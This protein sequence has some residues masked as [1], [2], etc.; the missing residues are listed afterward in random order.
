MRSYFFVPANKFNNLPAIRDLGVDEIIIDFEDS[1]LTDQRQ[2]LLQDIST[3]SGLNE[4][5]YRIPLRNAFEDKLDFNY[6]DQFISLGIRKVLVPKLINLQ[7]AKALFEHLRDRDILLILLI[8]HPRLLSDL[9]EILLLNESF[10]LV[11]ALALGTHDLS[12]TVGFEHRLPYLNYPRNIVLFQAKAFN[13][14]AIDFAS[15][16]L[17]NRE[18]FDAEIESGLEMGFD[19]KFLIHPLQFQWLSDNKTFAQK[20][21]LWARN[22]ISHVPESDTKEINP[23]ILDGQIIEKAH[24]EE[25]LKTIKKYTD[26]I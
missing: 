23:F 26:G 16:D 4:F 24:V 7:E 14:E 1:L 17:K 2:Q 25:A 18:R 8:E 19:G 21:L 10:D 15:M 9:R 13:V 6:L 3:Y 11:R 5:Y 20:K 12:V 22:I